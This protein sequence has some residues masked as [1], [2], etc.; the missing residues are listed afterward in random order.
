MVNPRTITVD[1]NA[2]CPKATA[3]IKKGGELWRRS[4]LRQVKYLNNIVEMAYFDKVTLTG[5]FAPEFD[6]AGRGHR[7]RTP[8]AKRLAVC[9]AR[10]RPLTSGSPAESLG[11][12]DI[13][14]W[15]RRSESVNSSGDR[16]C[17]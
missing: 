7:V 12:Q 15:G 16:M 5:M 13:R 2:A 10:P 3:E 4:R 9:T 6:V 17:R 1:K 14:D 8:P 11:R